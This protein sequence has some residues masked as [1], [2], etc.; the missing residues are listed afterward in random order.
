MDETSTTYLNPKRS[1]Y[2]NIINGIIMLW[3][4]IETAGQMLGTPNTEVC[5]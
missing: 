2:L 5:G 1:E 4:I 3:D